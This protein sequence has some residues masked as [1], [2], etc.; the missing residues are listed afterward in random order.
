MFA[1]S[2]VTR[3]Q[4]FERGDDVKLAP[5]GGGGTKFSPTF[6]RI[7]RDYADADAVV[8]LTDL[9]CKPEHFGTAPDCPLFWAVW[10]KSTKYAA[11][12]SRVPFGECFYVGR[13]D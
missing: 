6:E 7:A 1:D 10:G 8:Y 13:L 12:A 2:K 5:L 11:L 4:E 3:V 9:E